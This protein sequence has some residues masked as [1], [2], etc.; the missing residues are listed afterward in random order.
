MGNILWVEKRNKMTQPINMKAPPFW[1]RAFQCMQEAAETRVE[2]LQI[3]L[4]RYDCENIGGIEIP[5][6]E[7]IQARVIDLMRLGNREGELGVEDL[8]RVS[9]IL[10]L[11]AE[12]EKR[13]EYCR[14]QEAQ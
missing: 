1:L 6:A 12:R 8:E 13:K 4:D 9:K 3:C 7:I 11:L 10:Y 14:A 5:A 2:H